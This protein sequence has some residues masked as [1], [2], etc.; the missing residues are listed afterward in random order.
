MKTLVNTTLLITLALPLAAQ[1]STPS[2]AAGTTPGSRP[3][4]TV[5]GEIITADKLNSLW[6]TLSPARREQYEKNGGKS[7]FLD[8]YL[9]KR[10]LVQEALKGGFDKRPDVQADIDAAKESVLF[11]RYVRDVV[12]GQIVSDA[13]VRKFYDDNKADYAIPEELKIR[14]IVILPNGAGPRPKSKEQ[15]LDLIKQVAMELTAATVHTSNDE[16]GMRARVAAFDA[17][18]KRYSEDEAAPK[19]GD[20]GYVGKGLLDPTFESTAWALPLGKVSGIVETKFGYHLIFVE[21]KKAAGTQSFEEAAP[22]IRE[23]ITAARSAEIVEAVAKLTNEL[24]GSS[25]ISV[26][27]ENI[28]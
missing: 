9:R 23:G 25:K 20:L 18:A 10:L 14:H 12:A 7:A 21:A 2:S 27:P 3:V 28:R 24:R 26:Y 15:A 6:A 22:K 4:A 11:D 5:N 19:G 17:A 1:T 13:E 8:N 16:A